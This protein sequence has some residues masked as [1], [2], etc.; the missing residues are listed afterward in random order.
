MGDAYYTQSPALPPHDGTYHVEFDRGAGCFYLC[1]MQ[2]MCLPCLWP[3]SGLC[4][5][6]Q[7]RA[8]KCQ[9]TDR[10]VVFESGWLDH[11]NKNIPLDRIQDINVRQD[12]IQQCL[13]IQSVEIQTAGMGGSDTA[14]ACL[15]AP[16]DATIVR[17]VIME[18]RDA[19]VLGH[20]GVVDTR[21][22]PPVTHTR[23]IVPGAPG[24]V[25][26]MHAQAEANASMVNELRAIRETLS[27]LE[28]QVST[29][30][31]LM[32]RDGVRSHQEPQPSKLV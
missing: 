12:C 29:G 6:Q 27:R 9:V 24:H 8:Q 16:V 2:S 4:A 30:V 11:S 22:L 7:M 26:P 32:T 19:L 3:F 20:P 15:I 28:S 18:R 23:A 5:H 10:R 17:D 13:G 14:E 1:L 25:V 31:E 21:A